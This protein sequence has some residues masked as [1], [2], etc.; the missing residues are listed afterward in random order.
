MGDLEY[1]LK[2]ILN[3][4]RA[5]VKSLEETVNTMTINLRDYQKKEECEK[6]YEGLNNKID[7][8]NNWIFGIYTVIVAA[9][10]IVAM[11]K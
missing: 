8:S 2:E 9:V 3:D 6:M 5:T 4:L 7:I 1:S 11:F 10:S